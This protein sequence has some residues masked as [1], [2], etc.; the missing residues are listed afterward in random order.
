M[1]I[2]SIISQKGGVGKSSSAVNISAVLTKRGYRVLTVDLDPQGD[3][4][5][6]SGIH[7]DVENG[8]TE[9]LQ[10]KEVVIRK[11]KSYDLIPT[12]IGLADVE[13]LLI[14]EFAR[15]YKLKNNLDKYSNEYDYCVID[16]PPSLS[17]LTINALVAS[18]ISIA[19]VFME[20]FSIKA[21]NS[22]LATVDKVKLANNDLKLK[23]FINK[24]DKRLKHH[25]TYQK[26]VKKYCGDYL[27]ETVVRTDVEI[28]KSQMN[29]L[30]ILAYN[31]NSKAAE[32]FKNLTNEIL[33]V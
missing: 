26:N 19:P 10:G 32:D 3:T 31:E 12:D 9:L 20:T 33:E 29:S 17:L 5:Y 1:K 13:L 22:L 27:L 6:Y 14:T 24:L 11:T 18:H 30:N 4:T 15:E 23:L 7:G 2:I 25:E 21:V 8:T 28:S 16:C